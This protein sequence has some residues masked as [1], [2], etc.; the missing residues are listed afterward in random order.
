M[1]SKQKNIIKT[2]YTLIAVLAISVV[3]FFSLPSWRNINKTKNSD[4]EISRKISRENAETLGP[5]GNKRPKSIPETSGKSFT[6][7]K[8]IEHSDVD[9]NDD[10]N[11]SS[12]YLMQINGVWI[13]RNFETGQDRELNQDE[14]QKYTTNR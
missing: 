6:G 8:S 3:L 10:P 1:N 9:N 4:Q 13:F 7:T 11:T 12:V 5:K 2:T 14:I